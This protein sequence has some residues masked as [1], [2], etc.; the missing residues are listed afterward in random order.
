MLTLAVP[1][2]QSSF[3]H[4]CKLGYFVLW[5]LPNICLSTLYS[6]VHAVSYCTSN[7]CSPVLLDIGHCCKHCKT[8]QNIALQYCTWL[9]YRLLRPWAQNLW[10]KCKPWCNY[11]ANCIRKFSKPPTDRVNPTKQCWFSLFSDRYCS[12]KGYNHLPRWRKLP[13]HW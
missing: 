2:L 1:L 13:P 12:K 10:H 11:P 9:V 6:S 5:C 8:L 4:Y 3:L 7:V